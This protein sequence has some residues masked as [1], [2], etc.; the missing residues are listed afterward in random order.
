MFQSALTSSLKSLMLTTDFNSGPMNAELLPVTVRAQLPAFAVP[1]RFIIRR[2][3]RISGRPIRDPGLRIWGTGR[4]AQGAEALRGDSK[5]S[6][7]GHRHLRSIR[8][9][10][11]KAPLSGPL[12]G[13]S[14][15]SVRAQKAPA[16]IRTARSA[17]APKIQERR[18]STKVD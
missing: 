7:H 15:S 1:T 8:G 18:A 4:P 12:F 3:R 11:S 2:P 17:T 13:A 16:N 9:S 14:S 6:H 10:R 5:L